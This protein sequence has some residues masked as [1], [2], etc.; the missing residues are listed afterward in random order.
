MPTQKANLVLRAAVVAACFSNAV[1]FAQTAPPAEPTTPAKPAPAAPGAPAAAGAP[2]RPNAATTGTPPAAGQRPAA[3]GQVQ[4]QAQGQG[5]RP[6][7]PSGQPSGK[8]ETIEVT[9]RRNANTE[10]R[11]AS[12]SKIIITREDIEQYGDSNLGDVMRRL[13]GVTVGGR[14]G[15]GGP[16]A[17]R[18]MGGGFTQILIN[19]ER[20]SPGFSIEQITPE[21]VERIEILRAP[22]AETGTRAVAGTINVV[23]REPLRQRNNELRGQL[24]EERGRISPN[25]SFSRND[26]LGPT[27]TYNITVSLNREDQ[28]TDTATKTLYTDIPSG[29]VNLAQ[30]TESTSHQE[31]NGVFA[32]SRFQWRLGPGEMFSIQPFLVHNKFTNESN[33]TLAQQVGSA[34]APYATAASKTDGTFNVARAMFML[35]K[36]L[37]PTLR[38]ELRGGGGQFSSDT[39]SVLRERAA[40]GNTVLTQATD[41][42]TKDRSWNLVGKL[43]Y[44]WLDGKHNLVTGWEYEDVKRTDSSTTLLNGAPLLTDFGTDINVETKRKALYIQDEWDPHP[45]FSTYVG[46][47][48]EGIETKS[49]TLTSPVKNTSSVLNPLAHGVWRFASPSRDQIRV[50]LTQSYRAPSTQNLVGRPS[51]NTLFPVPGP[52]TSVTPDRAGNPSL[53]PEV[54]NGIDIAYENY[55]EG[56]GIIS[57]NVFTRRI[58][59]LIRNV[60]ARENVTWASSPRWVTRPQNLGKAVTSGVEFD[61]RFRLPEAIKNAPAINLRTNLSIYDSKVDSVP[62]P[63]NRINEQPKMTGNLGADYRFRGTPFSI[64]GNINW[65][66]GFETR[67]TDNQ[68]SK[69][70]TKRVIEGYGLWT[71]NSSA[72][73]RLTVANA[74]PR[75]LITSNILT[76]GNESQSETSN[77]KTARSVALRLEVRL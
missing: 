44:A 19:G 58:N 74:A 2:A 31:R 26:T 66:P 6:A 34:P 35:N 68:L 53:K 67:L 63:N 13:P 3:P 45:Q 56:G 50:S 20:V 30:S 25:L 69:T 42:D 15:R 43:S 51:L 52:N 4:G 48:W 76:Q 60:T 70:G 71:I 65:T 14:P 27:G 61:A 36:R 38:M 39:N 64:G 24:V 47:R 75:D 5:Q 21:M 8:T 10:R 22:T 37:A 49:R 32:T 11:D 57:V 62:G 1:S 41:S 72:K 46:L 29:R 54:A 59:D 7:Q 33:G 28:L 18:G 40:N 55:L 9:E 16:P 12:A 73:L 17:M 23:L 77:G